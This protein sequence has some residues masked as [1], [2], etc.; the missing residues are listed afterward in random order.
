MPDAIKLYHAQA[1]PNSRRVRMFL[2]E[3]GISLPLVSVDL[4]E[5]EQHGDAYRD[6][7]SRRVVPTLVLEDGTAI[8]EVLAIWRYLEEAYPATPLLGTTPK[9]KALVTM[10][11]RRAELEGFAAVMEGVRN[12]APRLAGRAIAGPHD[13]AQIPELV[14][15]SKRRVANF[16]RDMDARLVEAPCIA[17]DCVA[18]R[19]GAKGCGRN[20]PNPDCYLSNTNTIRASEPQH[21]VQC[22]GG[23]GNLGRLGLVGARSKR[24]AD[25]AFVSADRRLDLGPQIVAAGLLPGHAA[26]FGDHPQMAVALCRG[27]LG[28]STRHRACPRRHDDGSIWMTLG[29][30]LTDLVLIVGAVGREGGNGIGDLTEQRIR[31]RG[32]VDFLPGHLN[33]DDLAAIGIDADVQLPPRPPAGRSVLFD[34]PFAGSAQLQPGAVHEQMQRAGCGP[35]RQRHFQRL[36]P[37]AQCGVVRHRQIKPKQSDD[38][39]DQPLGLPQPQAKDHAHRQRGGDRQGRIMRLAPRRG[40]RLRSPRLDRLVGKPNG[41][42]AP[43]LQGSVIF[44]PV[45]DPIPGLGDVMAVFGMVLE[46]QG[47][48]APGG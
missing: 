7:N 16:Y 38:G 23:E 24:I 48:A 17:G 12:A 43:P 15:R 27:G 29:N 30:R 28:R 8:G 20:S 47:R 25:H 22:G 33:G 19:R 36:P 4:A 46:R 11:E 2:A 5:G 39:F 26:A 18:Q 42:A 37:P 6:I 10:W 14:E 31:H 41:Q 45:R 9:D 44:C 32:I 35:P 3:K 34:Q 1:S 40:S 21:P 13:Y